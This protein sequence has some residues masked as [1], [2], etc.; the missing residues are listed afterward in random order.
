MAKHPVVVYGASGYTGMLIMD[1]LIDQ[2]IPFT[3][4]ARNAKRVQ[5]MMAQRVVRLES[6]TYEI[7]ETEHN[8]EALDQGVQGR[9]GGLQHRRAVRELRPDRRRG[10][11]QGRLPPHRH[12]RRA[13]LHPRRA[14]PVRRALPPGRPAGVAVDRLHVHLRGD[15]RRTGAR[16]AGHR[17][18]GDRDAVPRPARRRLRR[19]GRLHGLDLRA[20]SPGSVLPVGE[21]AGSASGRH[22]R[23]RRR[24]R[25][26]CSR[27][28]RCPGAAPR[29]RSTSNTM[30]ACAA[31]APM[32]A[33]TTT[34]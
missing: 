3:A 12:H 5:E 24:S 2:Q 19:H 18:A 15:R 17:R 10:G 16:D 7:I 11:A 9:Q 25:T 27:C 29:C 4:V 21:E 33:S 14:R 1:W 23:Q 13:G 32:S 8:V 6:A 22:Q 34:T 26:S 30:R 28:S 31:A 20:V